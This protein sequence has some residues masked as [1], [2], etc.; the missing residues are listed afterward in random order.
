MLEVLR[1]R[2]P[3][4]PVIVHTFSFTGTEWVQELQPSL[5]VEKQGDSI[6]KLK[7]AIA[8][9]LDPERSRPEETPT[10]R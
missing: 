10:E 5:F 8:E 1:D 4:L 9:I 3:P 6:E 7:Q 2:R